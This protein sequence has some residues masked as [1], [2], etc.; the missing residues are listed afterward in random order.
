MA[1]SLTLNLAT[2][3]SIVGTQPDLLLQFFEATEYSWC[4]VFFG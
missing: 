3:A 4:F 1:T 2:S